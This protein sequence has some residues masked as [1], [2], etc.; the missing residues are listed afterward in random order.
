MRLARA[1]NG[2]AEI[3]ASN[4]VNVSKTNIKNAFGGVVHVAS[5]L[6]SDS[7]EIYEYL[8]QG[9]H[10]TLDRLCGKERRRGI[11]HTTASSVIAGLPDVV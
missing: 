11:F 4:L 5:K 1:C 9:E 2:D 8:A 6:C 10:P 3:T 7:T